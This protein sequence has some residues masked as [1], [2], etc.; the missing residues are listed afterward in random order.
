MATT[1][2]PIRP[3]SSWAGLANYLKVRMPGPN[4]TPQQLRDRSWWEGKEVFI[5]VDDYDPREHFLRQPGG[6]FPTPHGPG[7]STSAFTSS[8]DKA[9]RRCAALEKPVMQTM[10]DLAVPAM[11]L[12]GSPGEDRPVHRQ[13]QA[14]GRQSRSCP[15]PFPRSAPRTASDRLGTAGTELISSA[16]RRLSQGDQHE[17][18]ND[19]GGGW[20]D[21]PRTKGEGLLNASHLRSQ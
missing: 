5:L 1:R 17:V 15:V 18:L 19:R 10:N 8:P 21:S 4:V 14:P 11:L 6:G 16:A 13:A 9:F 20:L 3:W 2:P 12:P 7:P